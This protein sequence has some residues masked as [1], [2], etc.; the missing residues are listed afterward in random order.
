MNPVTPQCRPIV[1]HRRRLALE[2]LESRRLLA[3][4]DFVRQFD[5]ESITK[6]I[7]SE[8]GFAAAVDGNLSVIGSPGDDVYGAVNCGQAHLY[9]FTSGSRLFTFSNPTPAAGDAFGRAVAISGNLVV[10][11]SYLDDAGATDAGV[12][13]VFDASTGGL[14]RTIANPQPNAFDYFG[15]SVAISGN[16][17]VV[18]AFLDDTIAV[19]G[20]AAYVFDATT[21]ALERTLSHPAAA[22]FDYFGAAVAISG[23]IVVVGNSRGDVGAIDAGAAFVFDASTGLLMQTFTNPTPANFDYFGHAVA[24]SGDTVAVGAYRDDTGTT[25]SGAAYTFS[26][27][28]G[29]LLH[30]YIN[31][32]PGAGD[33]FGF[34]LGINGSSLV[35]GAYRDDAGGTDSGLAYQFNAANGSLVRT[36][37][38]P[39]PSPGD[40]Y[41]ASIAVGANAF[42]VTAYWDDAVALDAGTSYTYSLSTGQVQHAISSPVASASNY[43]GYSVATSGEWVATGA[44]L[45]DASGIDSGTVY[46][47]NGAAGSLVRALTNPTP[48]AYDNF[49]YSVAMS[50]S[51]VVVGAPRDDANASDSGAVHIFDAI[52]GNLIRSITNPTPGVSDFFGFSVAISGDM[53]AVSAHRDDTL[54]T[55]AGT[56]YLFDGPSGLLLSTIANPTPAAS[57][58]FGYAISMSHDAILIG[59][60]FDDTGATDAGAAYIFSVEAASLEQSLINPAPAANDNFGISVSLYHNSAVIGAPND[61][62]NNLRSGAAYIY[63]ANTG[64]LQHTLLDPF[65]NNGNGFGVSLDLNYQV[66]A[67]GANTADRP[68]VDAGSVVI[69]SLS[70]GEFLRELQA[71]GVATGDSFGLSVSVGYEFIVVGAPQHDGLTT[72]RGSAYLFTAYNNTAPVAVPGGPYHLQEGVPLSLDA[73]GSSDGQDPQSALTYEWDLDF[74]GTTFQPDATGI[75]PQVSFPDEIP[76]R[77]IALR[78]TDTRGVQSIA[79]TTLSVANVSPQ[80]TIASNSVST[81]E[82]GVAE[83][84][85]TF[86]DVPA[87]V[88]QLS[89]SRGSISD[90]GNGT[91]SWSFVPSDGP[92]D[93]G[94]VIITA[95]DNDGGQTSVAFQLDVSNLPP[96]IQVIQSSLTVLSGDQVSNSGTY[97]DPGVDVVALAASIG[98]ITDLGNGQFTWT[99]TA[100]STD[101][102]MVTITATDSDGD[103]GTVSFTLDVFRITANQSSVTAEEGSSLQNAG[104]YRMEAAASVVLSASIGTIVD[105]A[106]GTWSWSRGT[107]DGPDDSGP[108]TVTATFDGTFVSNFEFATVVVNVAPTIVA[109]SPSI[110]VVEG[111]PASNTGTYADVGADVVSLSTSLG[112]IVDLGAGAW[113][114]S[115]DTLDGP[116]DSQIVTIT[117]TD[118]DGAQTQATFELI[119]T[120][121]A[122]TV[123]ANQASVSAADGSLATNSGTFSD[124]GQDTVVV[125]ASIGTVQTLPDGTWTWEYLTENGPDESQEVVITATD[126]DGATATTTFML[127]DQ[128]LAQIIQ[129]RVNDGAAQRSVVREVTVRFDMLVDVDQGA[130]TV[131]RL[132]PSGGTVDVVFNV[133]QVGNQSIAILTFTGAFVEPG[134][135]SLL[136]GEY[137]LLVDGALVRRAGTQELLDAD[138]NGVAGGTRLF[139]EQ[140][141]DN[142]FR[143]FG[144]ADGDRDVD[145]SDRNQFMPSFGSA[146]GSPQYDARFDY[147]GDGD[148]DAADR[149]QFRRNFRR[150]GTPISVPQGTS[151][152]GEQT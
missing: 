7:G 111:S 6:Q 127:V 13:H 51:L 121:A 57:D 86:A 132:G 107:D 14:L 125:S 115:F 147:D 30:T 63:E 145:F 58:N 122:P 148:V 36:L 68:F 73:S 4:G 21:G 80:L 152:G 118:S 15:S 32:S 104:R 85:G 43:F 67:V 135:G 143:L 77:T 149:L 37:N 53:V 76:S 102:A 82:G 35:I 59:A 34:A 129:F 84:M 28:S 92:D 100:L 60:P 83:N 61:M 52:S 74:D 49:G 72:D 40:F 70:S 93:S 146:S 16:R 47:H 130:F 66:V 8:F 38:N 29:N 22:D 110:S 105:N 151:A 134:S 136:D 78:V 26:L 91:W 54:A 98:D 41:G 90:T 45:D 42:I 99:H 131:T 123:A 142:F 23:N 109:A 141:A 108:V 19:D 138:G 87:D 62:I 150:P 55:D 89:A 44:Y 113:S 3:I 117:G 112:V 94:A 48:A 5:D 88:V 33:N 50:N 10:I 75:A 106:D 9:D 116:S 140:A 69:Y 96:Q 95:T 24:I 39:T 126:D 17:V 20:G 114:W 11:G 56:V 71:A 18:G 79:S 81:S 128:E 1:A 25:N 27:S 137:Q 65:P 119:V 120:N 64:N 103:V 144:D 2:P 31:P 46:I 124:L 97:S 12:V 139:G 101:P 133:Q